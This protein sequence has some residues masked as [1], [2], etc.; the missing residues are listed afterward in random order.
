MG[1][2]IRQSLKASLGSYIGVGVG[3]VNQMYVSTKMLSV[4]QYALSRLLLENAILF[5]AFAHLGGPFI[6]DKFFGLFKSD[7]EQHNGFLPFLLVYPLVGVLAFVG[8]YT[9]STPLIERY[10]IEESPLVVEYHFLVVPLSLFWLYSLLLEAY[11]RNNSRIAVPVFIRE[12]YLRLSGLLLVLIFG[13]GWISFDLLLY[14]IVAAY[15]L[16]VVLLLIY[17]KLLGKWYWRRPN[18]QILTKPLLQTMLKYGLFTV[19]GALGVN[20]FLFIDRSMLAS[21]RGLISTGIFVVASYITNIIDIPRKAIS[22][23]SIPIIS[24]ALLRN[25]F[26]LITTMNQRTAL[27][28]L[29]AGGLVFLLIWINIDDIFFLLPKSEIY[30]EG[31][32]V[33]LFLGVVKLFDM[34]TGLTT[35]I[36][37]YSSY[38]RYATWIILLTALVGVLLNLWMIPLYGYLGAAIATASATLLYASLRLALIGRLFGVTSFTRQSAKATLILVGVYALTFLWPDYERTPL[39]AFLHLL[40][41]SAVVGAIVIGLLW[42]WNISYEINHVINQVAARLGL[43]KHPEL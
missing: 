23:I 13:F 19:I 11:C 3:V 2:V 21:E 41:R 38:Y 1:I 37:L 15:G 14:L 30:S 25:D 17:I 42:K 31:K 5:A 43:K 16:S 22:Q 32:Y 26:P 18:R 8:I 33:V 10:F 28:Q 35:E 29:I 4:E 40:L 24:Q 7:E 34:A 12:V 36:L 27:H 9:L 6:I 39:A 20:I